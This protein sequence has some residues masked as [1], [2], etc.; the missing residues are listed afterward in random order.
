M[1]KIIAICGLK[2]SGKDT[3]ADYIIQNYDNWEKHSFAGT[4]KDIVSSIFGWDRKMLAGE[5]PEDRETREE[6]DHYWSKK[7]K[8]AVTPRL[9][10]QKI[11]T[12]IL[13]DHFDKNIWIYSLEHK[14]MNSDKNVIVT[15][16]RFKNEIEALKGLKAIFI[17]VERN[18]L[19]DWFRQCERLGKECL[20]N[21]FDPFLE[22]DEKYHVLVEETQYIHKSEWD[23]I[24][25]DRPNYILKNDGTFEDLYKQIRDVKELYN[26]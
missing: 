14:L 25:Y 1:K 5:T 9:M 3:I 4:V 10:L 13:R 26:D 16:C 2:G 15:D 8:Y 22:N 21:P 17:R 18:P 11:G 24:G 12:D 19:P 6:V 20:D 23:W 7:L